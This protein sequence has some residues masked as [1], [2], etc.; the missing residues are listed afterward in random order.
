MTTMERR[1]FLAVSGASTLGLA[2]LAPS[3]GLSQNTSP[4]QKPPFKVLYSNDTTNITS[5]TSP[6]RQKG[7]PFREAMLQ[8]T[9]DEVS[10]L[11]D[12]HFL[13]PGLGMVPM[14][15][16]KVLPLKAHYEWIQQRY[17]QKPDS[18]GNYVLHGGD[19]VKVF[20][21]RCREKGQA[22]FISVRLNDAHHKEFAD[23][24]PGDKPG[25]SI[26]M[27]VT[28]AYVEH[29][30]RRIKADSKRGA[31]L[32]ENWAVPEVRAYKLALITELCENYDLDGL[33][34]DFMRFHRFFDEEKTG[35]AERRKIMTAFVKEVRAVLNRTQRGDKHRW[36]CVR[37]PCLMKG[38]DTV[39]LDLPALAASGVEMFNLSASYFTTQQ[40]DL[41]AI[42]K[43]VPGAAVYLE[44][45]HSTWN[46][47]KLVKGYDTFT[48]RRATKEQLQTTAHLAYAR[49]AD[50]VSL[51]NFVYYREHGSAGRGPFQEPPFEALR[52]LANASNL[53][54]LPQHWFLA[55]GWNNP[56]VRPPVL[57]RRIQAGQATSFTLE[58]AP[59]KAGWSGTLRLR[60]QAAAEIQAG[61]WVAECN[62][63]TLKNTND[64]AEPFANPS[65][66]LL[67]APERMLAWEVPADKLRDGKNEVTF[68]YSGSKEATIQYLDLA[69]L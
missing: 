9:V 2:G 3:S 48:F 44:L 35:S 69:A 54:T 20:I 31:D 15:P 60:M 33:E 6:F 57:P 67:G 66:S 14:W 10:G 52:P 19:V 68:R 27:S 25:T 39:G 24:K 29:P 61:D 46:G 45:C 34:L 8:A 41:E 50:G 47:E 28:K 53:A 36:L 17:Q 59:P 42:R 1:H 65:P 51:F 56:F 12:A 55:P 18:F 11:V 4:K 26:G 21:E 30:E 58:M 16:S 64:T 38:M 13:Q 5:C 22:A 43:L 32:V 7:E 37:I 40:T 63:V 49:G 23:P 62:G